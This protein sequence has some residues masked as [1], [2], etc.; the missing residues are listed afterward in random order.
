MSDEE[1]DGG[2]VVISAQVP[3]SE[4]EGYVTHLR[5]VTSGKVQVWDGKS[6]ATSYR[7]HGF[8]EGR[9]RDRRNYTTL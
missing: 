3:L 8:V 5:T 1:S 2:F 9:I 4:L 7:E 6:H